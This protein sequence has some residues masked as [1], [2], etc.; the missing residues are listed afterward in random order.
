MVLMASV[1]TPPE[2]S[3]QNIL[4]QVLSRIQ[5]LREKSSRRTINA[6]VPLNADSWLNSP[7]LDM[8]LTLFAPDVSISRQ[9]IKATFMSA[10]SARAAKWKQFEY[11]YPLKPSTALIWIR[12]SWTEWSGSKT[13]FYSFFYAPEQRATV[14]QHTSTR[15][16]ETELV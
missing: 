13:G 2:G 1:K 10:Y 11:G 6:R 7:L 4:A 8:L 14:L 5:W 3:M 15:S 9:Q 12:G 16:V